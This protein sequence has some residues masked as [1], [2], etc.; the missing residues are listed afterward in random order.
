[1]PSLIDSLPSL[2]LPETDSAMTGRPIEARLQLA[3]IVDSSDD[4][5]ISKDLRGVITSWNAAATRLFGYLPDEIIGRSVLVLIPPELHS[6]EPEIL[7]KV[8][9]GERIEHFETRRRRKNGELI[10][11]SLTISPIR[12][13]DGIIIGISKIARDITERKQAEA[14][15]IESEHMA[16]IG[17]MAASIAH[18]V[19]NP[20][21]AILNLGYLLDRNPSLD[22][23]ARSYAKLLVSEVLRVS[24]ITRQTLSFYRD[25][26]NLAE[27]DVPAIL[28]SVLNLLRPLMEQRS[29][30]LS[31]KFQKCA[32]VLARPGELRQ[33][34]TNL[35]V[36]AIDALPRGGTIGVSAASAY[37]GDSVCVSIADNGPGIPENVRGK[38]FQPFFTTKISKGTGLGLWISQGI[39]RKYGGSI[40]MRT[41][42]A[43]QRT[44]GTVFRVCLPSISFPV[45]SN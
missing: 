42:S 21:E 38:V 39:L 26:S 23:E 34:F 30:L 11:I 36:N 24:E 2:P 29:I 27:V 28:E 32:S 18:E 5:I 41:S 14:A 16:S 7:R 15:L 44:T 13:S 6:E 22:D 35:M 33:V 9:S 17:R 3:A 25:S 43:P 19:N 12:D 4:A 37:H 40:R 20:L 1:M 45:P 31:T 8:T 10:N